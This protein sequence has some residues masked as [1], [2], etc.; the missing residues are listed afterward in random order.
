MSKQP[1]LGRYRPPDTMAPQLRSIALV[2]LIAIAALALSTVVAATAVSIGHARADVARAA[3]G[4]RVAPCL[5]ALLPRD[6]AT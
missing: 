1:T 6:R 2:Q 4:A 5:I 3:A